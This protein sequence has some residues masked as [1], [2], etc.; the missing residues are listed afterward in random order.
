MNISK[1]KYAF[2][3]DGVVGFLNILLGKFGFKFRFHTT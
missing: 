3:R 1:F 2:E